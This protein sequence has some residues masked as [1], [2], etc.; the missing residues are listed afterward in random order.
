[1]DRRRFLLTSLG[2]VLAAPL[3]VG[4]QPVRKLPTIG[5]VGLPNERSESRWQDGFERGLRDHGYVLGQT[6]A[7]EVRTYTTRDELHNALNEFV[8]QKVD[9]IFVGQ[10]FLA[11]AARQATRGIPIVCGSCGDPTEI[12]L[13]ASLARPGGNVTG[14]AS[15]SAELIGKRLEL[16]K[17]LSPGVSRVAV[18]LFPANPGTRATSRAL[19]AAGPS[20][21]LEIVRVEIRGIGDFESAFRSAARDRVGAVLL[22]DDPLLR[23]VGSQIGE[24]ALKHRLPVSAGV[25]ELAE[26]GALMAY[27]PDR[28]DLYRRAVGFVDKILK[29]AKP[30]ELPFEQPTK[31]GLVLNLKT[32]KALGLTI[33]PSLLARADQV[34]NRYP[35]PRHPGMDR[36]VDRLILDVDS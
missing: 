24:L 18:F 4:A 28:V 36:R 20:L 14:L 29:G 3:T 11:L 16:V 12:G 23:A 31:F 5:Y 2:G 26:S 35:R 30:G 7:V 34:I 21:G 1:V 9:V 25:F 13:A 15:L 17:E 6:I 32:A 27:G 19:D 8:R 10:P 33:P 22:Q